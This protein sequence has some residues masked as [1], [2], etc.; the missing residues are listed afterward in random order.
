MSLLSLYST[1]EICYGFSVCSF[2]DMISYTT[3][4]TLKDRHTMT[5]LN[6]AFSLVSSRCLA[7]I[8]QSDAKCFEHCNRAR[9]PT[10]GAI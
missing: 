7:G 9:K 5:A 3:F 4:V 8:E 10:V 6:L 1:L 2:L